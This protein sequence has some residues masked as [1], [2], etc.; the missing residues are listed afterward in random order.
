[1]G[2]QRSRLRLVVVQA[3]FGDCLV[4]EA[5]GAAGTS[6]ILIDGG[7]GGTFT[8]LEPVLADLAASGH[9]LDL[10][11]LSHVDNDHVVGLLDL[12]A[13]MRTPVPGARPLPRIRALWHNSFGQAL[14][15]LELEPRARTALA[16]AGRSAT[17]MPLTAAVLR[18]VGEGDELRRAAQ[19]LR[20][21][22]NEGF[23]QGH[24]RLD[25]APEIRMAGLSIR[26]L[27]PS[28][29]ILERLRKQWER[30]LARKAGVAADGSVPNLSSIV[31]LATLG[32][33]SVLLT[34]DA[35]GDH[36]LQ[37]L[38]EADLL[39]AEGRRHVS[40]LKMPH[41]GSIRNIDGAFLR[42]VTADTYVVSADGRY[43]NPDHEALAATVEAA[44]EQGRPIEIV[45]TNATSSSDELLRS[46]PPERFRYRTR[47]LAPGRHSMVVDALGPRR[48]RAR[49][50]T[51]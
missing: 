34:G 33:R 5:T 27:G 22:I 47:F 11:I 37:G 26:I 51:G 43:G 3:A 28:Q 30:W 42:A 18:G 35:R 19:A 50:W 40:V 31:M 49:S 36:I 12:L 48:R 45:F 41:H 25:S 7:P 4:L 29:R 10:A 1:M 21:P 2:A 38:A 6:R 17:P 16:T 32:R 8:H 9:A 23:A 24:V 15:S 14:G 46:H 39:D 13:A 20:I 44:R